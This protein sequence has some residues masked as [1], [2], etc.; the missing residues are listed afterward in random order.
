MTAPEYSVPVRIA[1]L[2]LAPA[3]FQLMATEAERA[4]LAARFDL[5]GI[6]SLTGTL[7]VV[8]R[9][10]GADVEGSWAATV[11]QRCSISGEPVPARVSGPLSLRFEPAAPAPGEI[12]LAED[13][14]DT[15]PVEDGGIDLGEALAQSLLLALDPFPRADEAVLAQARAHLLSEEQAAALA[16]AERLARS[17]FAKLKP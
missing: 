4:A 6:A 14:L 16:E 10:E 1:S 13:A 2:G 12:E 5:P 17:P 11:I 7:A 15:M 9:G 8:R 3:H